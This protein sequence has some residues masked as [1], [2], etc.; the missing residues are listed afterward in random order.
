MGCL[1]VGPGEP[2]HNCHGG[3]EGGRPLDTQVVV[4]SEGHQGEERADWGP[5]EC[6]GHMALTPWVQGRTLVGSDGEAGGANQI[7]PH[8]LSEMVGDPI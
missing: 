4:V 2:P 7:Q 3:L 8:R 6:Q 5:V 1:K